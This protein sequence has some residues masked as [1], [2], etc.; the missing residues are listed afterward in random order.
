MAHRANQD[1]PFYALQTPGT[2]PIQHGMRTADHVLAAVSRSFYLTIRLLPPVLREPVGLAYLLA[3]ASDTVADSAGSPAQER[4]AALAAM[5]TA[6]RDGGPAPDLSRFIPGVPDPSE[7]EL[8][9]RL[10]EIWQRLD[11]ASPGDREEIVRV[12]GEI[13]RGQS[14]DLRRFGG[15]G[16]ERVAALATPEELEDYTYSVA[17]CVGEFWTRLCLRHLPRYARGGI[18]PEALTRLGVSFG[19]GLQL[20]NILRDTPADLAQGRC[21]LPVTDLAGHPPESLRDTPALARPTCDRWL[22]RAQAHLDDG[23]RYIESIRPWR[24]RLAC[25][26]PWALGVETLGLMAQTRPLETARRI[27]VPRAEVRRLLLLGAV[28]CLGNGLLGIAAA[29]IQAGSK[30]R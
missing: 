21:Y 4:L 14:L 18:P 23:L 8:L 20:V 1:A 13:L 12:L 22:A 2:Q 11:A 19:K 3:R 24:L 9:A 7:K 28:A 16:P 26:L 10:G 6:L 15:C 25:F 5:N 29:R 17:G 30:G 27:K